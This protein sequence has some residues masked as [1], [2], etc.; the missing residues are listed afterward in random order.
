MLLNVEH[1]SYTG[2]GDKAFL[3]TQSPP[4]SSG[5]WESGLLGLCKQALTIIIR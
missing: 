3:M 4:F 5:P 2:F 1:V